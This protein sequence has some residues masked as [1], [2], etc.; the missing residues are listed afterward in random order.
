MTVTFSE[1]LGQ[2]VAVMYVCFGRFQSGLKNRS[3]H[4]DRQSPWVP[5][6][7]AL[8]CFSSYVTWWHSLAPT[9]C[10]CHVNMANLTT[11]QSCESIM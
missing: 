1:Y 10:G 6:V 7:L 9:D 8:M 2:S 5:G 11:I 3:D 4:P